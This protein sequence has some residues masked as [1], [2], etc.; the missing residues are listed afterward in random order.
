MSRDEAVRWRA[1]RTG[2]VVFTNGG[3]KTAF[4]TYR[5]SGSVPCASQPAIPP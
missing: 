1:A 3:G 5:L 4:A 2:V